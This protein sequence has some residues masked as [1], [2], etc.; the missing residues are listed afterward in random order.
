M[1]HKQIH[2][3]NRKSTKS[4]FLIL[5]ENW[6]KDVYRVIENSIP[7][8]WKQTRKECV[9]SD[10]FTCQGCGYRQGS[11]TSKGSSVYLTVHH[12]YPRELGGDDRQSNLLC[13]CNICH[14]VIE[15]AISE[16]NQLF[17]RPQIMGFL[18][19]YYHGD[20]EV[21][22]EKLLDDKI[23]DWRKW[24]YGAYRKPR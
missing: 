11:L 23:R 7:S 6:Q 15:I 12:M 16:G 1:S 19:E 24:V 8:D 17:S 9:K 10:H 13:L 21:I 22:D 3:Y 2:Q 18:D 14:D 5:K 4:L 20:A